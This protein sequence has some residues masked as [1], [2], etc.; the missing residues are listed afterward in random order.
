MNKI[1][2]KK[3]R[4][5]NSKKGL[6]LLEL[7]VAIIILLMTIGASVGGLNLSYQSALIGAE[8]DD[9]QS[10]AQR[11]WDIIMEVISSYAET[12]DLDEIIDH[13]SG[14]GVGRFKDAHFALMQSDMIF[15]ATPV[16]GYDPNKYATILQCDNESGVVPTYTNEKPQY[17]VL[18][19][20]SRNMTSVGG[21][22]TSYEVYHIK[23]YV[24]Y[25]DDDYI[26][27]E[28]EVNVK[29]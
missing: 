1:S 13:A 21:T 6:T 20:N 9:A 15:S 26:T 12:G 27:C 2:F 19:V 17:C 4:K 29:L 25:T 28:G 7:I 3:K 10:L 11:N 14:S 24:Y 5:F 23:V 22:T 18:S 8:K 16:T